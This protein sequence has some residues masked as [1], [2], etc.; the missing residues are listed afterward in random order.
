YIGGI[1]DTAVAE[2]L[3]I[4]EIRNYEANDIVYREHAD[5]THLFIVHSGQIDIQYKTPSGSRETTDTCGKGDF[6]IWSALI[7]PH[8][9]TS[10][11]ICRSRAELLAF[12]AVKLREICSKD[13]AFGYQMMTLIAG[14]VRRRLQAAR[15]EI[16]EQR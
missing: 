5:S 11:G 6:L 14:V 8:K 10:I 15:K 4:C 9:T 13:T 7:V 3:T 2:L 16:L 1:S 12:D